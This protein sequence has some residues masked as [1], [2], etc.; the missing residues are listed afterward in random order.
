MLE[1]SISGCQAISGSAGAKV[2]FRGTENRRD[3]PAML[4][5]RRE[6]LCSITEFRFPVVNLRSWLDRWDELETAAA[7]NPFAMVVMAHLLSQGP[8]SR[9]GLPHGERQTYRLRGKIGLT[10]MLYQSGYDRQDV[11][12]LYHLIDWMIALPQAQEEQ[13]IQA[14]VDMEKEREMA[15]VLTAERVGERRG[16]KA[17]VQQGRQEE[18]LELLRRLL[19]RKFGPLPQWAEARLAQA[20]AA[21]LLGWSD[22]V[23]DAETLEAVFEASA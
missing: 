17:G 14:S 11:L 6:G 5:Y 23:L 13:F 15:F 2:R 20:D 1:L 18:R 19:A 10:R 4:T 3:S 9:S 8:A 7:H 12:E 16:H 22:R 21:D